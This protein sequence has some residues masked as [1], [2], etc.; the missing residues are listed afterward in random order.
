MTECGLD[1]V[2]LL[3]LF[4]LLFRVY[5][6]GLFHALLYVIPRQVPEFRCALAFCGFKKLA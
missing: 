5:I 4:G 3:T 2:S 1:V 6:L